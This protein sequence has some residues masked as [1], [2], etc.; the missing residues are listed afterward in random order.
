MDARIAEVLTKQNFQVLPIDHPVLSMYAQNVDG[1]PAIVVDVPWAIERYIAGTQ[2]VKVVVEATSGGQSY[3]RLESL[4][5]GATPMFEALIDSL[6]ESSVGHPGIDGALSALIDSFDEFKSMLAADRGQL[7]EAGVRGLFA[8]LA[9][10][11]ALRGAGY[12]PAAA[13]GSWQGPYR[14]AKDFVLP[15]RKCVEVKSVRRQNHRLQIS[16]VDQLDPRGEELRLAVLELDRRIDGIGVTLDA[17]MTDV[18]AWMDDDPAAAS[19]FAQA[20]ATIGLDLTDAY[21]RQWRFD[22]GEWR[23]FDVTDGFP[24]IRPDDVP[25][26]ITGVR[27]SIDIDQV[28]DYATT[29]F[30]VDAPEE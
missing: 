4:V 30:W 9:M 12:S 3:L 15:G 29:A 17:I 11:T 5:P 6:L 2:G 8:E 16:N 1:R 20:L 7:S 18:Q 25:S 24:R 21:Y 28:T 19:L 14:A 10:L 23:W 22:L 13:V 26:P 27:Y